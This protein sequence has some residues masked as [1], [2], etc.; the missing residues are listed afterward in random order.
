MNPNQPYI[1]PPNGQNPYD[2]IT[3]PSQQPKRSLL[4]GNS[5]MGRIIIVLGGGF[6]LMIILLV[7]GSLLGRGSQ[8][9]VAA[10]KKLAA[11]QQEIVRIADIG[12]TKAEA[13]DIRARALTAKLSTQSQQKT[14]V[15]YL[16]RT[17]GVVSVEELASQKDVATDELLN[18]ATASNSFDEVFTTTLTEL[19]N[20]YATDL[21]GVY[22]STSNEETKQ[23]LSESYTSTALLLGFK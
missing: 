21:Q 7:A 15:S 3:A 14:L 6:L 11:Q 10:L 19:L 23:V 2:F 16:E 22:D 12:S 8:S 1:P 13:S 18:T 20:A 9:N 4:P 17:S 5:F